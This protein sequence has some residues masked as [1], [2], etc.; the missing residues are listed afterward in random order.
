MKWIESGII[1]RHRDGNQEKKEYQMSFL[2]GSHLDQ[3]MALQSAVYDSLDDEQKFVPDPREFYEKR[4]LVDGKG[5]M[6]GVF[7]EKT[8]IAAR[9]V[10]FPGLTEH[11]L[12]LE[13]DLPEEDLKKAGILESSMVLPEYR[14]NR[15]QGLMLKP[16]MNELVERGCSLV[17]CTI[18]PFN[19]PSLKNVMDA[20]LLIRDL[21]ARGG[22]YNGKLRFLLALDLRMEHKLVFR[23][24]CTV[25]NTDITVQKSLLTL[26]LAGY[27]L[28]KLPGE[29][30]LFGIHYGKP[31]PALPGKIPADSFSTI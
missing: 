24:T 22:I 28:K 14:G 31:W 30:R 27:A 12:G 7:V 16:T 9:S 15:L 17:L 1:I 6:I 8:M 29:N 25:Q 23:D 5:M 18:S 10:S 20:G 11:N 13:L 26:G 21:K 3:V 19:Y 2:D 4:A